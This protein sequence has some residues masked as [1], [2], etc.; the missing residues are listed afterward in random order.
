MHE[1]LLLSDSIHV[2]NLF[3]I[4][5]VP[6]SLTGFTKFILAP[7]GEEILF[8][9]VVYGYLRERVGILLGIFV[10]ALISTMFHFSLTLKKLI[11]PTFFLVLLPT[12]LCC[13]L[14]L[15]FYMKEQ[16]AFTLQLYAMGYSIIYYLFTKICH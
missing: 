14:S 16:I 8:R 3:A 11:N 10:Q 9:G 2:R 13:K 7:F 1:A 12:L 15:L 4:L 6:F 5:F